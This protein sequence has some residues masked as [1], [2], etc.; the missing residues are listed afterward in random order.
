MLINIGTELYT[1]IQHKGRQC[2]SLDEKR[3]S[4][5]VYLTMALSEIALY[6]VVLH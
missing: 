3:A 2:F 1:S 5:L 4:I 6:A